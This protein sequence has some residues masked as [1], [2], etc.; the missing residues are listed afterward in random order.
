MTEGFPTTIRNTALGVIFTVGHIGSIAAMSLSGV[1]ME[2]GTYLP[3]AAM[4]ACLLL[5]FIPGGP[6]TPPPRSVLESV[7]VPGFGLD[8]FVRHDC[9]ASILVIALRTPQLG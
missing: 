6:L 5:G 8:I 3:M 1:L 4:A 9:R 2:R 7:L